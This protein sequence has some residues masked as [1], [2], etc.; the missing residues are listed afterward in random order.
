MMYCS[1]H[2]LIIWLRGM[3]IKINT[4][5]WAHVAQEMTTY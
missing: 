4:P 1:T 2:K 3:K 5:H